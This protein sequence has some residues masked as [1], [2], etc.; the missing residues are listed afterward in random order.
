MYPNTV[1]APMNMYSRQYLLVGKLEALSSGGHILSKVKLRSFQINGGMSGCA[2]LVSQYANAT[3]RA[4]PIMIK[5]RVIGDVHPSSG[6]S[7]MP[8]V[9]M[10]VPNRIRAAPRTSNF[11]AKAHSLCFRGSPDSKASTLGT[12]HRAWRKKTAKRIAMK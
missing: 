3:T 2:H 11:L 4:T 6:P 9:N 7:V 10:P 12:A 1:V 5:G 8:A